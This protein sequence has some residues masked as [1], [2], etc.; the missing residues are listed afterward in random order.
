MNTVS[1]SIPALLKFFKLTR[2]LNDEPEKCRLTLLGTLPGSWADKTTILNSDERLQAIVRLEKTAF[3][4]GCAEELFH[5]D[6]AVALISGTRLLGSTD[7]YSWL[8]GWMSPTVSMQKQHGDVKINIVCP[9]T[10]VHVKKYSK[11]LSILVQETPALYQH[12]VEPFISRFPAARTQWV[13][14]ILEGRAEQDKILFASEEVIILPDM[15]WDL[16][17]IGSLYLVAI[18]RDPRL[19]SLRD[20]RGEHVQLLKNIRDEAYKVTGDRWAIGKGG[21][22]LF[23]HYQPSYYRFHVHIVNGNYDSGVGMIVGQAHLL[24]D[25]ISLLEINSSIFEVVT[26]TYGLGEQHGLY[27][28]MK[29]AQALV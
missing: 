23:I 13:T 20:L 10:E 1:E 4:T 12:I 3:V 24:E 8:S 28:S 11:Q 14:E 21:L 9:A 15:K 25:V 26:L 5:P 19:R 6:D 27:G 16:H 7:I 17:T 18:V 22:R 29:A 2:I